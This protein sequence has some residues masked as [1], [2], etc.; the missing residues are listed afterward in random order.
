MLDFGIILFASAIGL[1]MVVTTPR[2]R[3]IIFGYVIFLSVIIYIVALIV[4]EGPAS[5]YGPY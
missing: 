5:H 1:W 2:V 4:G 3:Q